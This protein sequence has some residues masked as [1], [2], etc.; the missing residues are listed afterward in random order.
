MSIISL[1][2]LY[3]EMKERFQITFIMTAKLNQDALESLFSVIRARGGGNDHPSPL[4][5]LRRLRVII[6]GKSIQTVSS[7]QS[8]KENSDGEEFAVFDVLRPLKSLPFELGK[9]IPTE[10]DSMQENEELESVEETIQENVSTFETDGDGLEY[11]AGA[12]ARKFKEKHPYVGNFSY[13]T[14][15]EYVHLGNFHLL[16]HDY[17]YPNSYIDHLS[18]GG[19]FKPSKEWLEEARKI[20]NFFKHYHKDNISKEKCVVSNVSRKIKQKYPDIPKDLIEYFVRLRT[21]IRINTLNRNLKQKKQLK[22]SVKRLQKPANKPME[23]SQKK[24]KKIIM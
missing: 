13:K 23:R 24:M 3:V 16:D 1:R 4:E 8:T 21:Y 5:C 17:A 6:L 18:H 12:V 20:D 7:G 19:L 2:G 22:Q 14:H 10:I 11:V 15:D 9:Q